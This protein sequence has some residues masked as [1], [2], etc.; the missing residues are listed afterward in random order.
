MALIGPP[1]WKTR[2]RDGPIPPWILALTIVTC[3]VTPGMWRLQQL[4][5]DLEHQQK[6]TQSQ[7]EQHLRIVRCVTQYAKDMTDSLQERDVANQHSIE[8]R[9]RVWERIDAFLSPPPKPS[10]QPLLDAID[11]YNK[12]LDSLN[13]SRLVNPYPDVQPCLTATDAKSE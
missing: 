7:V 8:D 4:Q 1:P 10:P 13:R 9:K 6:L 12:S 2:L 11:D 5:N 3:V